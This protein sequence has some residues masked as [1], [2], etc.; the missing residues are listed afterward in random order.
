[1]CSFTVG[2]YRIINRYFRRVIMSLLIIIAN[3]CVVIGIISALINLGDILIN[4]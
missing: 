1:M 2:G 4:P 3:I